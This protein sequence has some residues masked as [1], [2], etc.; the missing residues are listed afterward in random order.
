MTEAERLK[1]NLEQMGLKRMAGT[2]EL[3]AERAAQLK[4][5]YSGYLGRLI[6]E[7]LAPFKAGK[8]SNSVISGADLLLSS[9]AA[10]PFTMVMHELISNA[11][12]YGALSTA[13]GNIDIAWARVP[14][15]GDLMLTWKERN[16]PPVTPPTRRGFGSVVIERSLRHE[17]KGS[18]TLA[19]HPDGVGCMLTIPAAYIL[20]DDTQENA[21]A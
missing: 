5:S 20:Q 21:H 18:G 1:A 6:E 10:M 2:F 15:T 17:L 16:G 7:E 9:Q 3:E 14:G 4:T 12:K 19:F 13:A 8:N 11:A